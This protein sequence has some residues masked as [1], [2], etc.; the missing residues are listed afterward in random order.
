LG[1]AL[2]KASLQGAAL[3]VDDAFADGCELNLFFS[4]RA[5]I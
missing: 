1:P 4:L 2:L 5:M 3:H